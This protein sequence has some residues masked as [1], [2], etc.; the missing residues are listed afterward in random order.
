LFR[1]RT[2]VSERNPIMKIVATGNSKNL[3]KEDVP[4]PFIAIISD[5]LVQTFE[6]TARSPR[7]DKDMLHFADPN[8]K[9]L[10]LNVTN[11]RILVTAYGDESDNWRGQPV[12]IY[13]D[14]NV[15][16]SRGEIVGGIRLRIPRTAAAIGAA[17]APTPTASRPMPALQASRN[18]AEVTRTAAEVAQTIEGMNRAQDQDNLEEWRSWGMA[19]ASTTQAQKDA[20]Q[21]ASD[22]AQERIAMAAAPA[23]PRRPAQARG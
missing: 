5:V 13:V 19:I 11:K 23:A 8:V 6:K 12:E 10:G 17:P 20:M 4:Q 15:T 1:F 18:A 21:A 14:P 9:P 16:N 22:H 2:T 7:E 3:R